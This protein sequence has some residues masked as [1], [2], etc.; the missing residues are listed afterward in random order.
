MNTTQ[1][2]Q[3]PVSRLTHILVQEITDFNKTGNAPI[4]CRHNVQKG[5]NIITKPFPN[6]VYME[7]N[8]VRINKHKEQI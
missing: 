1:R 2:T 7:M 8:K 3:S 6:A 4:K 5:Q